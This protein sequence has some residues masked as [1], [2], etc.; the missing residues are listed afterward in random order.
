MQLFWLAFAELNE[1]NKVKFLKYLWV[2]QD[3]P[4]EVFHYD[5]D[6]WDLSTATNKEVEAV[7]PGPIFIGLLEVT[8]GQSASLESV[9]SI[10]VSHE[11]CT[12]LIPPFRS[13]SEALRELVIFIK[14]LY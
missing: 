6:N 13:L 14:E 9:S 2:E 3:L 11:T 7:L 10:R 1:V 8:Q 5:S 12:V 4:E